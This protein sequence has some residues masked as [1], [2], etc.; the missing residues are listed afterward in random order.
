MIRV[1]CDQCRK[2]LNDKDFGAIEW[3]EIRGQGAVYC[4]ECQERNNAY[5]AWESDREQ[6][7]C[8]EIDKKFAR[9]KARMKAKVFGKKK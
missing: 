6:E 3:A 2:E 9:E 5:A 4:S 7:I 1:Y 8:E